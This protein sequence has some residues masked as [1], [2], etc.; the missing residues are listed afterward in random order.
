[1]PAAPHGADLYQRLADGGGSS[2]AP[3]D[4]ETSASPAAEASQQRQQQEREEAEGAASPAGGSRRTS[5]GPAGDAELDAAHAQLAA[6]QE[7]QAA[8]AAALAALAAQNRTAD[9]AA[10]Q[11]DAGDTPSPADTGLAAAQAAQAA[12][13]WRTG[14]PA[15]QLQVAHSGLS[16]DMSEASSSE[17]GE[18]ALVEDS[19]AEYPR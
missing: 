1:M 2:T 4:V 5:P 15:L 17:A 11:Q 8:S 10:S 6:A 7:A 19:S 13:H 12:P 3:A 14:S 16:G 9:A 18:W